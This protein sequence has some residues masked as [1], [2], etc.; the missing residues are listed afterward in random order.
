MLGKPQPKARMWTK[1]SNG[2]FL[3]LTVW[4]GKSDPKAEVITVEIRRPTGEGW[5]TVGRIAAYRTADGEYSKLPERAQQTQG[6]ES[7]TIEI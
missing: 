4:P 5:K 2:D 1:L 3:T 7:Y 6:D